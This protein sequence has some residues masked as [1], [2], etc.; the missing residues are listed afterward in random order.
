M[1]VIIN[2]VKDNAKGVSGMALL[3]TPFVLMIGI[4]FLTN[5]FQN[6][7]F[8]NGAA[9]TPNT[10]NTT[11]FQGGSFGETCE[12]YPTYQNPCQINATLYC[13]TINTVSV[14]NANSPF[15]CMLLVNFQCFINSLTGVSN[16]PVP[17]PFAYFSANAQGQNPIYDVCLNI[18][19]TAMIH[20]SVIGGQWMLLSC[21]QTT[22]NSH[23]V[24]AASAVMYN[25]QFNCTNFSKIG[26]GGNYI[27]LGCNF[28]P[29]HTIPIAINNTWSA[30]LSFNQ[31]VFSN[32][33]STTGCIGNA[34]FGSYNA[35]DTAGS[36][37]IY[38]G[39][40]GTTPTDDAKDCPYDYVQSTSGS[41]NVQISAECNDWFNS[42]Q[43]TNGLSGSGGFNLALI[44]GFISGLIILF[45]LA[46]GIGFSGGAVTFNFSLT[47]N[48]QGTRLAQILGLALLLVT[49]VFSL[50]GSWITVIGF[51]IGATILII[52]YLMTFIGLFQLI[53]QPV[54]D[55]A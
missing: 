43:Q 4:G 24:P 29:S 16:G 7:G 45:V 28:I 2:R 36:A 47:P 50:F 26:F 31:T 11:N 19:G 55:S 37:L 25:G 8:N 34:G 33:F 15:T 53:V 35:C 12:A 17:Q 1:S 42:V 38:T 39:V 14:L 23:R 20:S 41:T 10:C 49:P 3:L 48:S 32:I 18:N 27:Y 51:G 44:G 13:H 21:D 46:L 52:F 9:Y 5:T 6:G 22:Y 30:V 40:N 54:A